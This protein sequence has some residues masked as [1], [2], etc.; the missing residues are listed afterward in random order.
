MSAPPTPTTTASMMGD[1]GGEL[2]P[3]GGGDRVEVIS[4]GRMRRM[5]TS[6]LCQ[7]YHHLQLQAI[8]V[9]AAKSTE[10][11]SKCLISLYKKKIVYITPPSHHRL[12]QSRFITSIRARESDR[13]RWLSETAV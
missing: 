4:R 9:A 1:T 7:R 5:A 10:A 8:C 6:M 13:H 2:Q 11:R 3:A 12:R